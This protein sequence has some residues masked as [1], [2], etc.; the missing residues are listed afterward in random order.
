MYKRPVIGITPGF[1]REGNKLSLGQGYS[2]GVL[3]AGALPFILPLGTEDG[4]IDRILETV[5]GILFS[6][7][8]DIDARYFGQENQKCGGEISPERDTFELQLARKA[9][10]LRMPVLGICRGMQV[11]NV[12]LGGTLF[13]DIHNGHFQGN[14]LKHW[15]EAPDW[16]PIHDVHIKT[17]TRLHRIYGTEIL[18]VNSFHH[19]SVQDPGSGLSFTADSS[20]GVKEAIE[21]SGNQFIVAVQWH[22][23]K[24]WQENPLHLK[25][26]EALAEESDTF[27][28]Y[29]NS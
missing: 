6:G 29:R 12:A 5:D 18:G 27:S 9:I 11:L 4:V 10:G 7:G 8:A 17:G 15:Q 19:Q 20:D 28:K 16:Y 21:G 23:E 13:Q 24:M 26:F 25:L 14:L 1:M 22:P 3:K 2:N